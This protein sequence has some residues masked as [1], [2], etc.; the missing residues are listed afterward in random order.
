M[1]RESFFLPLSF[2]SFLKTFLEMPGRACGRQ[3]ES[4]RMGLGQSMTTSL[5]HLEQFSILFGCRVML[6]T[7]NISAKEVSFS[8]RHC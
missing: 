1:R 8:P 6:A 4:E 2:A 7:A 5:A 3:V